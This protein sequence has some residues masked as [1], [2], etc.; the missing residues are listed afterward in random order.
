MMM[1]II[2][3]AGAANEVSKANLAVYIV[4]G[5]V[6]AAAA[7]AVAVIIIIR[8]NY[9]RRFPRCEYYIFAA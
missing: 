9:A 1:I 2:T 5:S 8:L 4:T 7:I 3:I 6:V